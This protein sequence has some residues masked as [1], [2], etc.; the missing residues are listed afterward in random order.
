[1][2]NQQTTHKLIKNHKQQLFNGFIFNRYKTGIINN[3]DIN[4]MVSNT[5]IQH[6]L[7][8]GVVV[9]YQTLNKPPVLIF[10]LINININSGVD[11]KLSGI[12]Q[13]ISNKRS[14]L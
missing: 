1:M 8:N 3:Y 7:I 12:F 5:F 14:C 10:D 9:Y 4:F 2:K 13:N 11:L 6:D